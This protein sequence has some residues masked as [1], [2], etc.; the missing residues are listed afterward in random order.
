MKNGTVPVV[1]IRFGNM[2][3]RLFA[4]DKSDADYFT[5]KLLKTVFKTKEAPQS[6]R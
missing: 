6:V 1:H 2:Y 4:D 3:H 5:K